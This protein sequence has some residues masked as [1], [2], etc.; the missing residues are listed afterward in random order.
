MGDEI[1][2]ASAPNCASV[3]AQVG[4]A[5]TRV[6]SSTRTPDSG[7]VAGGRERLRRAV[8]DLD[9]FDHRPRCQYATLVRRGPIPPACAPARRRRLPPR[10]RSRNP[11]HSIGAASLPPLPACRDKPAGS[12]IARCSPESSDAGRRSGRR[13]S[14]EIPWLRSAPSRTGRA[15]PVPSRHRRRPGAGTRPGSPPPRACRP[16]PPAA[17]HR[18]AS[19]YPP[20][21]PRPPRS[22]QPPRLRQRTASSAPA[23]RTR[24]SRNRAASDPARRMSCA[25]ASSAAGTIRRRY[26][27]RAAPAAWRGRPPPAFSTRSALPLQIFCRS[28]SR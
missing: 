26:S 10:P 9:H 18:A 14:G 28:S 6:R 19:R 3:R 24:S 25:N 11:A 17:H 13:A 12:A 20:R 5:S 4:P 22:P 15:C 21:P 1:A 23:S 7:A 8:G 2:S 27:A 16:A